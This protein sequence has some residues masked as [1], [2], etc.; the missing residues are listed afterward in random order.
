MPPQI[1]TNL[2]LAARK[3]EGKGKKIARDLRV[4]DEKF[5]GICRNLGN[6]GLL[7][8]NCQ[9]HSGKLQVRCRGF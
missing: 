5:Q 8:E 1:I 9:K 6:V 7:Q 3:M 4:K 2:E